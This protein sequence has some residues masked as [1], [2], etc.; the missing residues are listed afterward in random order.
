MQAADDLRGIAGE[1]GERAPTHL[2]AIRC[3]LGRK[4]LLVQQFGDR[5]VRGRFVEM[6]APA[7]ARLI[8]RRLSGERVGQH[9]RKEPVLVAACDDTFRRQ[10]K[11]D[12]RSAAASSLLRRRPDEPRRLQPAQVPPDGVGVQADDGREP[13]R[14]EPVRAAAKRCEDRSA[15]LA[16]RPWRRACLRILTSGSVEI[17]D[18]RRATC[19]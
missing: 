3:L 15:P 10:A 13:A 4:T 8:R 17:P 16:R 6:T 7:N 2:D 9:Q 19:S 18:L 1:R 5:Q 11:D 14:V 12:R